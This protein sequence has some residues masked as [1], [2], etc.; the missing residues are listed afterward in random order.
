MAA[1]RSLWSLA[2]KVAKFN[3]SPST[4]WPN[5][6]WPPCK[7]TGSVNFVCIADSLNSMGEVHTMH[8][9]LASKS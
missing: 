4:V 3:P 1:T 2:T 7:K 6:R 8:T 5:S 9:V